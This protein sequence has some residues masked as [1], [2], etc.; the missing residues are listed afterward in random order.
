[1]PWLCSVGKGV[2][3]V[4]PGLPSLDGAGLGWEDACDAAAMWGCMAVVSVGLSLPGGRKMARNGLPVFAQA[5]LVRRMD[6]AHFPVVGGPL[7]QGVVSLASSWSVP[8][9]LGARLWIEGATPMAAWPVAAAFLQA[10]GVDRGD[11]LGSVVG[12]AVDAAALLDVWDGVRAGECR[13]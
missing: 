10:A 4:G 9:R 5:C 6:W 2:V 11:V 12:G 3:V 8:L 13:L 1:M 7:D